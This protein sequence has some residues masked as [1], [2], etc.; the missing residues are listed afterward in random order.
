MSTA[1][2]VIHMFNY[3]DIE[4][5]VR[6]GFYRNENIKINEFISYRSQDT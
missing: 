5:K 2:I 4:E 1:C 3:I 6:E